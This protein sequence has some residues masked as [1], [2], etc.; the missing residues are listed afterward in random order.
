M[1]KEVFKFWQR[2]NTPVS[3]MVHRAPS[4]DLVR[5]Q[6]EIGAVR[7]F[8]EAQELIENLPEI[9]LWMNG[10]ELERIILLRNQLKPNMLGWR[11]FTLAKYV[12]VDEKEQAILPTRRER[13]ITWIK[14]FN[15][16]LEP[17]A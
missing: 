14:S 3:L 12:Q 1:D 16:R 15:W 17:W 8:E 2:N 11:V 6:V 13:F 7:A 9:K 5:A 4:H 10:K